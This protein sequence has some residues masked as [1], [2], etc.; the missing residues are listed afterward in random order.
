MASGGLGIC[1]S[2]TGFQKNDIGWPQQ[3]PRKKVLK[4]NMIFYASTQKKNVFSKHIYKAVSI[5]WMTLRSSLVIFQSLKPLQPQWPRQPHFIKKS[6][7]LYGLI[8]PGT[9]MTNTSPF[10][11]N[12]SSKIQFFA[13][14]W[15]SFCPRLLR[16]ANVIFLK[17]SWLNTNAQTSWSH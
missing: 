10:L 11:W 15:Y 6:T 16:P 8:I 5:A 13:N 3:P 1:V 14:I 9:Q 4:F 12:G 7:D 17:I 2:S